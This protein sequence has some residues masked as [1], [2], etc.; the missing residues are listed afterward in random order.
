MKRIGQFQLLEVLLRGNGFLLYRALGPRDDAAW[1]LTYASGLSPRSREARDFHTSFMAEL[2]RARRLNHRRAARAVDGG[3]DGQDYFIAYEPSSGHSLATRLA[4]GPVQLSEA[5]LIVEAVADALTSAH[6]VG[7]IHQN[8]QPDLI[9]L[10]PG[11]E[12]RVYGFG[13]AQP[14]S[15]DASPMPGPVRAHYRA[16]EQIHGRRADER[17]DVFALGVLLYELLL[18]RKPFDGESWISVTSQVL[19]SEPIGLDSRDFPDGL[20]RLIRK[21]LNKN[22]LDR[23]Q[24]AAEFHRQMRQIRLG[25]PVTPSGNRLADEHTE[26]GA[27]PL[28]ACASLEFGD[29]EQRRTRELNDERFTVGRLPKNDLSL[30]DSHISRE[31]AVLERVDGQ[32]FVRDCG[33]RHGTFLNG[34]R[35]ERPTA[36]RDRDSIRLGTVDRYRLLFRSGLEERDAQTCGP[37]TPVALSDMEILIEAVRIVSSE[38]VSLDATLLKLLQSALSLSRAERGVFLLRGK[39]GKFEV[40]KRFQIEGSPLAEREDVISWSAVDRC[41]GSAQPQFSSN[42][43]EDGVA[44][45]QSVDQLKLKLILCLPLIYQGNV[46]GVL[47]LDSQR[48]NRPFDDR[49]RSLLLALTAFSAGLIEYG[50]MLER[51][52]IDDLTGLYQKHH[53]DTQFRAEF[54]R[55]RR[56]NSPL[57]LLF[58]DLDYF[59]KINDTYGHLNANDVLRTVGR[60]LRGTARGTDIAARFGG[61]EFVLLAPETDAAM[62]LALAERIRAAITAAPIAVSDG[63]EVTTTLSVG[64]ST[65]PD[66][67][68]QTADDLMAAADQALLE[69]KAGGRNRVVRASRS[70]APTPGSVV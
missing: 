13:P 45:G 16:P 53:F 4:S 20:G 62:A 29:G 55:S 22:P 34:A 69:A 70:A 27:P 1:L 60:L 35:V 7:I 17:T 46:R 21:A 24:T 3:A 25:D 41:I 6:A 67:G 68:A 57:S 14:P 31:H 40:R 18:A 15:S 30:R 65:Y 61:E 33:S 66:D 51:A 11:N 28:R 52:T 50:I 36:L 63:R 39:D 9:L 37:V 48:A 64:V 19:N 5:L 59:K 56:Y 47:Y 44:L 58:L 43:D 42:I 26:S 12:V 8:L 23:F 49:Q 2:D 54:E 32:W 10:E 38:F